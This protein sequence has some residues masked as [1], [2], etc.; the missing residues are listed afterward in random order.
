MAFRRGGLH[1]LSDRVTGQCSWA[2]HVPKGSP[3]PC[4]PA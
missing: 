1:G 4:E 3:I 2:A